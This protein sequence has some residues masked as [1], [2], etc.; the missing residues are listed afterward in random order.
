MKQ[1]WKFFIGL[2]V[3]I[4]VISLAMTVGAAILLGVSIYFGV[5]YYQKYKADKSSVTPI[6]KQ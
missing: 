4:I 3:A 6:F 1:I 2:V 5:K